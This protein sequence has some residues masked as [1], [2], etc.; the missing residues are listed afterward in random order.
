MTY[1]MPEQPTLCPCGSGQSY[2]QCCQTYHN[3]QPAPTAEALMRSRFTAYALDL[4]DYLV[5]TT[6]PAQQATLKQQQTYQQGDSTHWTRLEV[7][8]TEAGL[9]T[10]SEGVVE[11]RAMYTTPS[12]PLEQSYHE[13]SDFICHNGRWYFIYPGLPQSPSD[14]KQPGRNDPCPCGSGR[15]FKKCCMTK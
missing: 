12:E 13:R 9:E 15:K 1:S 14:S 7:I 5:A 2:E 11:F 8:A 10:D 6:W 4:V 3:G